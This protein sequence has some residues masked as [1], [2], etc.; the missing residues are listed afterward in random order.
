MT[1]TIENVRTALEK[2]GERR[3]VSVK[4][5][6]RILKC[7]ETKFYE[8]VTAGKIIAYKD[9]RNTLVDYDSIIAYQSSLPRLLARRAPRRRR[10][11]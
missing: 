1:A 8:L 5:A 10:R 9:G 3:L 7:G 2:P 4:E 11:S 6:L